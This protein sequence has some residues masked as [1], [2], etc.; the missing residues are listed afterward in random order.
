MLRIIHQINILVT[1]LFSLSYLAY[2]GLFLMPYLG[3]IQLILSLLL[4]GNWNNINL[5]GKR[6]LILYFIPALLTF[7][8][9]LAGFNP[10]KV[11]YFTDSNEIF[12]LITGFILSVFFCVVTNKCHLE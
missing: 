11:P 9:Y 2:I 6:F 1:L 7:T 4:F 10:K 5:T 12:L 3:F 8:Y